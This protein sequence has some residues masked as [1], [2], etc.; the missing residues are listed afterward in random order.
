MEAPVPCMLRLAKGMSHVSSPPAPGSAE[1]YNEDEIIGLLTQIYNLMIAL[2]YILPNEVSYPPADTGR[3]ALNTP[4]LRELGMNAQVI[5]LLEH[6]PHVAQEELELWIW[7]S[8]CN[9]FHDLQLRR[10]RDPYGKIP[11]NTVDGEGKPIALL[12]PAEITLTTPA[13][14]DGNAWVLDTQASKSLPAVPLS[15]KCHHETLLTTPPCLDTIRNVGGL[16]PPTWRIDR[17]KR[18]I[19]GYVPEN[20]EPSNPDYYR[21]E[22]AFHAP[23]ILR[24]YIEAIRSLEFFPISTGYSREIIET[25][26]VGPALILHV[27]L[28]PRRLELTSPP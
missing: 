13:Y 7:S 4:L 2:A 17:Y 11:P 16:D 12:G 8:P 27:P 18:D 19:P 23:G 15:H 6:L 14:P 9:Y 1:A 24:R 5:S 20:P 26:G 10:D 22:P 28:G 25:V 21:N 3:H